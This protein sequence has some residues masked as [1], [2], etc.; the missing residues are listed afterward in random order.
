M[1]KRLKHLYNWFINNQ[2]YLYLVSFVFFIVNFNYVSYPDEFVNI[3]A[4][5]L[6]LQGNLPYSQ[7]F[8]HHMPGAWILAAIFQIFSFG[9]FV[10]F[11]FWWAAFAFAGFLF[12]VLWIRKNYKEFFPYTVFYT[13]LYP[14]MGVYFWF[15]LF[16]ADSV[17]ALFFAI[18]FW[19]LIVQTLTKRVSYKAL[20]V[21]SLLTFMILFSSLTY[22]YLCGVLYLWQLYLFI[23]SKPTWKKFWI[24][25]AVSAAPYALFVLFL[26]A[27][28][29]F[30]DFLKANVTYNTEL[31][32][33]IPN[34]VKGRYFNPIKFAMTIIFNFLG[35]YIPLLSQIKH[36][37][38]YF[39]LGT[40]SGLSTLLLF[41]ILGYRNVFLGLLY[42][43]V[44]NFST[45]RSDVSKLNETDYQMTMFLVLGALSSLVVLYVIRTSKI[46]DRLLEDLKRLAGVIISIFLL[47]STVFLLHNAYSKYFQRY[48]QAMPSIVDLSY[49]GAFIN[50][51]IGEEDYYWIGPYHPEDVFFVEKGNMPGKYF[52]MMPQFGEH[53]YFRNDFIAQ[54]E[55]NKPAVIMFRHEDSIFMTPADRFGKFFLDW[56]DDKYSR[57]DEEEV[58]ILKSPS[59]FNIRTDFYILNDKEDEVLQRMKDTGYLK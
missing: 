6:L 23:T 55:K 31:Y 43:L 52:F 1:I 37:D 48:T 33:N 38:I 12:L 57:L 10:L 5:K 19:M 54:F 16:L 39:P 24:Y 8:D 44:L 40:L 13:I 59:T 15:H 53:E 14:L 28:Q 17:S 42:F 35:N 22:V 11:R 2:V 45:A 50:D 58:E 29:T 46:Q 7:I 49:T 32:V 3:M 26:L 4:G 27:T 56:M 34:Y 20:L 21:T 47:F 9:S 51:V 41:L 25:T 18:T 36:L 30:D